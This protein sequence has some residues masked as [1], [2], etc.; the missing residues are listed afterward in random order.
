MCGNGDMISD[1]RA[2]IQGGHGVADSAIIQEAYFSKLAPE[3][4]NP[5]GGLK[6][7]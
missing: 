3:S 6:A 7:A 2:I 4:V 1:V 5:F